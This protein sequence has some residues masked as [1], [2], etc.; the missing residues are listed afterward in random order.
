MCVFSKMLQ[1]SQFSTMHSNNN[2]W[3]QTITVNT[4]CANRWL[5]SVRSALRGGGFLQAHQHWCLALAF[6]LSAQPRWICGMFP[7]M[8][9]TYH[10][11]LTALMYGGR[12]G[13]Q[14]LR[15]FVQYW[16]Y[17]SSSYT[18]LLQSWHNAT[19]YIGLRMRNKTTS[20]FE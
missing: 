5:I 16:L 12:E 9:T 18:S 19:V 17:S 1:C 4:L 20:N 7:V 8:S 3:I 11:T 15:G 6:C 2:C 14:E 13:G 10:R